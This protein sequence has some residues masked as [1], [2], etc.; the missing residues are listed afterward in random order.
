M[1][2]VDLIK[3]AF[4]RKPVESS[5]DP[6]GELSLG[7]PDASLDPMMATGSMDTG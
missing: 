4:A 5:V 1:S 2:V 3:N 6:S 7:M